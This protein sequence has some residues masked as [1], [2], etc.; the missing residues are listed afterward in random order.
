MLWSFRSKQSNARCPQ[1]RCQVHRT[2]IVGDQQFCVLQN[3]AKF[4]KVQLPC[5]VQDAWVIYQ[6]AQNLQDMAALALAAYDDKAE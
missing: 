2:A 5:Q 4:I 3:E 1:R 6:V